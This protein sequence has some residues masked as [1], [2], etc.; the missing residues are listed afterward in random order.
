[1]AS[2]DA[3]DLVPFLRDAA[4]AIGATVADAPSDL[5]GYRF[6]AEVLSDAISG[7]TMQRQDSDLPQSV[8]ALSLDGFAVL[9]GVLSGPPVRPSVGSQLRR[10]RNQATIAR[11]WLGSAAP[12]LHLFLAAPAGAYRDPEWRQL[13][14]EIEGDDRV[15]RKLVWLFDEAPSAES[16]REFMERTFVARP[17]PAVKRSERLDSMASFALPTGWEDAIQDPDLDNTGLVEKLLDL[18]RELEL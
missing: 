4:A 9:I 15:C 13:A 10:Y 18:E 5:K 1:M 6:N 17:W 7:R 2:Y 14:T 12:N 3:S 16:A 11:S 8:E